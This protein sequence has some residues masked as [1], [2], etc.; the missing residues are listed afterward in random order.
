MNCDELNSLLL[1]ENVDL[2][3]ILPRLKLLRKSAYAFDVNFGLRQ[4]PAEPG[5]ILVRGPRQYGKSTWLEQQLRES[6][7]KYGPASSF[8]LNCDEI[9]ARDVLYQRIEAL[10]GNFRRDTLQKRIFIDEITAIEGWEKAL[11]LAA[12]QGLLQDVLV[13]T[14]G[15]K[16]TDLRRGEER[17]P[18]RKGKLARTNYVFTPLSFGE[19]KS[20]LREVFAEHTLEAYLVS[21]GS[22]P[23]ALELAKNGFLPE[24]IV[25]TTQDWVFGEVIRSGRSRHALLAALGQIYKFA[26]APAGYTLLAREAGLANNT[27][28]QGYVEVLSDLMVVAPAFAWDESRKLAIY[29]RPCKFHFINLLA[30]IS[31]SPQGLRSVGDYLKLPPERQ[32]CWLEWLTAQELFRRS[33]I[34]GAEVP[35]LL[36][37][38]KGKDHEIDFIQSDFAPLEVKHGKTSAY[39][40]SWVKQVFPGRRLT[41]VGQAH[42]QTQAISAQTFA[43]FLLESV[44]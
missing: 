38:W 15:S 26:A 24:Y 5:I 13:V 42:Y 10:V 32:S 3:G 28:A 12:D 4:L 41:V 1:L 23:A 6:Y 33:A 36:H 27:T 7:L 44:N 18:G 20:K 22:P 37:Y 40:F 25:S 43:E 21:G 29:R 31:F 39:E 14:T 16:A 11:K 19:F 17:L 2:G 34:A 30:A 35:E 9:A 8:Y